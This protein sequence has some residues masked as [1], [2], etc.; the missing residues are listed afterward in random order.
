L[1]STFC[2]KTKGG[3]KAEKGTAIILLYANDPYWMELC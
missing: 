2:L 3:A 1:F